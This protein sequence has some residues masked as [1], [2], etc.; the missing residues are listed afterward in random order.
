MCILFY[1]FTVVECQEPGLK[2]NAT[3]KYQ[4]LNGLEHATITCINEAGQQV[5]EELDCKNGTWS[6]YAYPQC[7]AGCKYAFD[8]LFIVLW[9]LLLTK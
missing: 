3:V 9:E 7:L 1:F 4:M 8:G 5:K 6:I 2:P